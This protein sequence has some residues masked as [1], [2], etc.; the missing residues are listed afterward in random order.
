MAPT[1]DARAGTS[2]Y[3]RASGTVRL[4]AY[5][6]FLHLH[7]RQRS[8]AR[9]SFRGCD[10]VDDILSFRY[11]SENRVTRRQRIIDVHD[12]KLRPVCVWASV[13]H[14]HRARFVAMLID[15]R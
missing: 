4:F 1:R 10:R 6:N 2:A 5:R 13:G 8:I 3:A 14:R 15:F 12:E 7:F 9:I 11:S